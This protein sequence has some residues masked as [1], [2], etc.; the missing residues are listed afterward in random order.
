MSE[1]VLMRVI[2]AVHGVD[3]RLLAR[4]N[5]LVSN[6][7]EELEAH[8][9]TCGDSYD[10]REAR[11]R[12]MRYIVERVLKELNIDF[13]LSNVD[14]DA[15]FEEVALMVMYEYCERFPRRCTS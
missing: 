7:V 15:F 3:D 11:K 5:K 14:I 2:E 9:H 4:L 8:F 13:D 12:K 1:A 6:A 10:C